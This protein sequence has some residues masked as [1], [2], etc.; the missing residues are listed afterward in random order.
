MTCVNCIEMKTNHFA[1][2]G[3]N[4]GLYFID[5]FNSERQVRNIAITDKT[6]RG[7]IRISDNI[8]ALTSNKVAL[9]GEDLLIFFNSE[10][11][12][13]NNN[14]SYKK[15]S[16]EIEGYSFTLNT[17][18]LALME[19]EKE[20]VKYK[21]LICTCKKYL[22][23]QKNGI[24]LVNPQLDEYK[25]VVD[26][27]YDT[28]EFEVYCICPLLQHSGGEW[29]IKTNYFLIGGFNNEKYIGQI[30]LYKVIPADKPCNTKIEF[31]QDIEFEKND[32]F[33]GFEGPI[34][35][36]IQSSYYGNIIATCYDG[37]IY[38]LSSP[39]LSFYMKNKK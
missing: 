15:I 20:K 36:I 27:F 26:D 9:G 25:K 7:G 28:G 18:G 16:R 31:L 12:N 30:K 4:G 21:I 29:N 32:N 14:N 19:M 23:G 22:P 1:M 11:K 34:S 3:L 8:I 38:K 33:G 24:L 13:K 35:C 10:K 2:I 17:N 39:D 6:F 5:L 37:N